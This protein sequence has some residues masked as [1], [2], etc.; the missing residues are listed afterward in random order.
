DDIHR[1]VRQYT[2]DPKTASKIIDKHLRDRNFVVFDFTKAID[3]P[4]TIRLG[5]DTP[6][7]LDE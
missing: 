4:L 5:W 3:D 1:I 7:K 2:D 6:L